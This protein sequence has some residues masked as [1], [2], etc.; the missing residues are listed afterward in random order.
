VSQFFSYPY[1]VPHCLQTL[2]FYQGTLYIGKM[3]DSV[4]VLHVMPLNTKLE[5]PLLLHVD[6]ILMFW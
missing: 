1:N 3:N 2:H 4:R 5:V 6:P